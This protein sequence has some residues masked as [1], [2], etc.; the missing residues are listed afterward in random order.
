MQYFNDL[1]AY[2]LY[3]ITDEQKLSFWLYVFDDK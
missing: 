3:A 2:R 1:D